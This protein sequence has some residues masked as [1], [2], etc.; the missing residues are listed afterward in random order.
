MSRKLGHAGP[1]SIAGYSRG[2]TTFGANVTVPNWDTDSHPS[3]CRLLPR[4]TKTR[5]RGLHVQDGIFVIDT[6][7]HAFGM[8]EDNFAA[9]NYAKPVN[10]FLANLLGTGPAG[11]ALEPEATKR[12]WQTDE[13][14]SILFQESFTDV[15]IYHHTPIYFFKDGLSGLSKGKEAIEKYPDRIIG[16]YVAV[17]PI[18]DDPIGQL[19]RGIAEVGGTDNVL[20]VKL[21]PVSYHNGKVVPWRMDD[22]AVAFPIFDR[23]RDIGIK[24]IGIHKS[25]PLG[26]APSTEAFHPNDIEGAA[27]TYPDLTFEIVHGGISFTEETAWLFGRYPNVWINLEALGFIGVLR[28]RK[29]AEVL[30]GLLAVSSEEG[31]DRILWSTGCMNY[32]PRCQLEA[33]M[34]FEMPE[35]LLEGGTFWPVPEITREHKRKILGGNAA[36]LYGLDIEKLK[37][38]IESDAFSKSQAEGLKA[39]FSTTGVA[40]KVIQSANGSTSV[41]AGA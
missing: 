21:Y 40:D 16:C 41:L 37:R 2:F 1:R 29:F 30:A 33:F 28:P 6:V 25:L 27:A 13:M 12:D 24:H 18:A 32:H 36:R 11:Y 5:E 8:S 7:T 3:T 22:P 34:N 4:T 15:G 26:P 10:D 35:D 14:A 20:G 39:P 23:A 9:P 38:A 17:D 19:E 31:I